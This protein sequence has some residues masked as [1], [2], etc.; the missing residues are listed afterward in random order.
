MLNGQSSCRESV[1]KAGEL[2]NTHPIPLRDHCK[3]CAIMYQGLNI[4]LRLIHW[5]DR[6]GHALAY[7]GK[8]E[9][10]G[11]ESAASSRSGVN[12]ISNTPFN[13]AGTSR[14]RALEFHHSECGTNIITETA[15]LYPS[16]FRR[17]LT[18][19]RGHLGSRFGRHNLRLKYLK[20]I[21]AAAALEITNWG[22]ISPG[23]R[24]NSRLHA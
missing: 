15:W 5:R 4:R 11:A 20:P 8:V 23:H 3:R 22:D 21:C 6:G 24:L 12:R 2:L 19:T 14:F 16:K 1:D 7:L 17:R 18:G 10:D 9:A 13:A